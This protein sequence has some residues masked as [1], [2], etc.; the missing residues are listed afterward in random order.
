MNDVLAGYAPAMIEGLNAYGF[1]FFT[2]PLTLAILA[3][4]VLFA[5]RPYFQRLWQRRRKAAGEPAPQK[6]D[7]R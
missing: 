7:S 3:M 1:D 5:A 4:I 2:R 6:G